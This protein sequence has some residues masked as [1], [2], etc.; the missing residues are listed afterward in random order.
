MYF[1]F[2]FL[3]IFVDI[4]DVLKSSA[5]FIRLL[6]AAFVL[7]HLVDGVTTAQWRINAPK[8]PVLILSHSLQAHAQ[9]RFASSRSA[10]SIF[11]FMISCLTFHIFS[12]ASYRCSVDTLTSLPLLLYTGVFVCIFVTTRQLF[13]LPFIGSLL[14]VRG[15]F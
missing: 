11:I 12:F 9:R 1:F 10:H 8:Q 2:V 6:F 4:V 14:V 3:V 15:Y 13:C 7:F 5:H